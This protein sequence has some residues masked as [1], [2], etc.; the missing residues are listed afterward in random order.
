MPEIH[1]KFEQLAKK[2]DAVGGAWLVTWGLLRDYVFAF[3]LSETSYYEIRRNLKKV[4]LKAAPDP[5][6][7]LLADVKVVVYRAGTPLGS[8]VEAKRITM[9]NPDEDLL[10]GAE[11]L[12]YAAF[13]SV[14][15]NQADNAEELRSLRV[16][17][18]RLNARA[19]EQDNKIVELLAVIGSIKDAV[20]D[21]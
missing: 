14:A 8:A 1:E 12:L 16:T 18:D 21:F 9:S 19:E 10:H 4:G 15:A 20:A 6:F 2:V 3:R 13:K 17:I 7:A 11:D 5:G